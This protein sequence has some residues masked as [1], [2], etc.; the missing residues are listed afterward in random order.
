MNRAMLNRLA[1]LESPARG[2][3]MPVVFVR[4]VVDANGP[5]PEPEAYEDGRGNVWRRE[6]GEDPE[7]FCDRAAAGALAVSPPRCGAALFVC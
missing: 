6:P 1:A 4:F 5:R 2:A 3:A 7:A